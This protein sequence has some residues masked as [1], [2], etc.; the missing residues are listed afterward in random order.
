[1]QGVYNV[2]KGFAVFK[3]ISPIA[4]NDEYTIVETKTSYGLS[5]YDHIALDGAKVK[6]NQTIVK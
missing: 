5:L 6:E 2:N 1:M 4:S 3:Q